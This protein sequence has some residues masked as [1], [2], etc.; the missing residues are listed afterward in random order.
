VIFG[1]SPH[2]GLQFLVRIGAAFHRNSPPWLNAAF[3]HFLCTHCG[4]SVAT[5]AFNFR[6]HWAIP[7]P[8]VH[9]PSQHWEEQERVSST[10]K[11]VD[12]IFLS[13]TKKRN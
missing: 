2:P 8:A 9:K 12:G 5:F 10:A 1:S 4:Q 11:T 3:L 6:R 7:I 13:C